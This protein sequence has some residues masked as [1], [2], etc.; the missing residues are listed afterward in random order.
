MNSVWFP[1]YEVPKVVKC[2]EIE[3]RMWLPET[4]EGEMGSYGLMGM[5]FQLGKIKKFWDGCKR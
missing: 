4:R 1:L 5:E 3:S 2:T